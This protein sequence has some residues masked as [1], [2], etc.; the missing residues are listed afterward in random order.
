MNGMNEVACLRVRIKSVTHCS[1]VIRGCR[2]V[3]IIKVR[4]VGV[5]QSK[6]RSAANAV[7]M[8]DSPWHLGAASSES[9]CFN[10]YLTHS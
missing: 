8:S 4:R 2:T 10:I 3:V 7:S 1:V 5:T 6:E 9:S